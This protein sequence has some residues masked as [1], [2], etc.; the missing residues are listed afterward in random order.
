MANRRK[1]YVVQLSLARL[2]NVATPT[3]CDGIKL[4]HTAVERGATFFDGGMN[5]DL[6]LAVGGL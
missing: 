5:G 6:Q 3:E 4:T 2:A 1:Q